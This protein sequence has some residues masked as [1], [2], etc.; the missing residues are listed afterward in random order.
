MLLRRIAPACRL[1]STTALFHQ[2]PFPISR[3]ISSRRFRSGRMTSSKA[4]S[5]SASSLKLSPSVDSNE[6]LA[7]LMRTMHDIAPL[8]L[9]DTSWDNVGLLLEAPSP[10]TS[11][12][13]HLCIDLTT[14]VCEEALSNPDI[15]AILCYHPIIFRGL[16]SLTLANSQQASLLKLAAN[17]I[18]IYSPHTSLDATTDGI[19]DWIANGCVG[20]EGFKSEPTP[21]QK[22]RNP[23]KGFEEA[24]MGRTLT[25]ANRGVTASTLVDR[26]K[27]HLKID[28]L[29]IALPVKSTMDSKIESI[30]V[31]AGSGGS[32]LNGSDTDCWVTGEMSH[33]SRDSWTPCSLQCI[34]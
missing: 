34:H 31:C 18:S 4:S 13:V 21:C 5:S 22:S 17:G 20:E 14:S 19:N 28:H 25:L 26:L 10:R 11:S 6:T 15:S 2:S 30:A 29:Q 16:K 32:V 9:A 33:V 12:G 27:R 23:P 7:R 3:P 1:P 24:G 8:T